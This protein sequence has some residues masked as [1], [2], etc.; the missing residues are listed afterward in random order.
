M[1]L[2]VQASGTLQ[3]CVTGSEGNVSVVNAVL[4]GLKISKVWGDQIFLLV[5]NVTVMFVCK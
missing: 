2:R 4:L 3:S 5:V 1:T